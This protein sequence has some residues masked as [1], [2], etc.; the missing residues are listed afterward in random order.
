MQATDA[1]KARIAA[2]KIQTGTALLAHTYQPPDIL[3]VADVKGDSFALAQ[4]GESITLPRVLVCGVR[5]MAETVK[6]LSPNKEVVLASPD[7]DCPMAH[8]ITPE[9]ITDFKRD[10]PGV[11]VV[12]YVNTTA[13]IK[14][15]SDVCVT[16]SS[17]VQIV[18]SLPGTRI[19]F[20]PDKN[21]GA[22]VAARC[23]DKEI[24]VWEG[25]CPVHDA[26]RPEMVAALKAAHP[27]AKVALHPECPPETA[28]LAD[29]VGSTAAI[30]DFAR[31]TNDDVIFV[32]ERGVWDL[33]S[34]DHPSRGFYQ[35]EPDV[36]TCPDMKRCTLEG[37]LAALEGRAGEVIELPEALRL[38]ARGSIENM[39]RWSE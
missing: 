16:S 29:M 10:N 26:V 30:L 21:L 3:D 2:L 38:R 12:A 5:F 27:G 28:A 22:Y 33:L 6:I 20:I 36:M 7:A 14:A 19:L 11:T 24:I 1:L 13:E 8:Q 17:A 9:R 4:A 34:R 37:V 15:V 32:T 39:L 35:V 23:P 31:S 25:C 18:R